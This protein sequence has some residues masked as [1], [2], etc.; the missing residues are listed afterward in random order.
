VKASRSTSL[1]A[2]R[3]GIMT[4]GEPSKHFERLVY[5]GLLDHGGHPVLRWMAAN[6][7]VRFDEN[8]N[9]APAKKR[10]SE[11]IDG[12]VAGVMA[13]GLALCRTEEEGFDMDEFLGNVVTA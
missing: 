12:I 1:V 8:M 2:M 4:L 11:K 5:A 7:V 3:Q 6:A 13:A 9:F 10:S